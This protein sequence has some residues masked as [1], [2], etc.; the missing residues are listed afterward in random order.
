[1]G[2]GGEDDV[3]AAVEPMADQGFD[4]RR[5][6]LAVAVHEQ[7]G[8]EAGMVEAGEEGRFLAEVA[9]QRH[10]LD[11]QRARG[12][13][14]RDRQGLVAAAVV[15]INHLAGERAGGAQL[16]GDVDELGMQARQRAGLVVQRNDDRK[17]GAR[18]QTAGRRAVVRRMCRCGFDLCRWPLA[19]SF[20]TAL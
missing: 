20:C 13:A 3:I 14:L 4:Q 1:M 18:Q 6:V 7:H 2:L 16:T 9:R 19:L 10:D 12:Q 8:V 5:R 15:D 11:V 17:P